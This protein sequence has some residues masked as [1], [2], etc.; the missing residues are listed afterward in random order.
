MIRAELR[1]K[2]IRKQTKR[3]VFRLLLAIGGGKWCLLPHAA[4]RGVIAVGID[5]AGEVEKQLGKFNNDNLLLEPIGEEDTL[6][7]LLSPDEV[8]KADSIAN[9][10]TFDGSGA[11]PLVS[12]LLAEQYIDSDRFRRFMQMLKTRIISQ[13]Q[14]NLRLIHLRIVGSIAGGYCAGSC[15][16]FIQAISANL[17]SLGVP[18]RVE[19]D[20]LGP[21]AYNKLAPQ[22]VENAAGVMPHF[23]AYFS[24]TPLEEACVSKL[25]VFSEAPPTGQDIAL[26]HRFLAL[27]EQAIASSDF[28]EQFNLIRPNLAS[29]GR[30]AT[31]PLKGNILRRRT[32]IIASFK[33]EDVI[34]SLAHTTGWKIER[35]IEQCKASVLATRDVKWEE[36]TEAD[37][38]TT[39]IDKVCEDAAYFEPEEVIKLL[40]VRRFVPMQQLSVILTDD[41]VVNPQAVAI[42]ARQSDHTVQSIVHHVAKLAG[43][44]FQ[45]K[46]LLEDLT[47]NQ[48][49]TKQAI[50]DASAAFLDAHS[51][52]QEQGGWFSFFKRGSP[53]EALRE[54]V[55]LIDENSRSLD[56]IEER[57]KLAT[58]LKSICEASHQLLID[59]L[60]SIERA[61]RNFKRGTSD[62]LA[63]AF[64]YRTEDSIVQSLWNFDSLT[65]GEQVLQLASL[66]D[67]ITLPGLSRMLGLETLDYDI[68][69]RR[70]V[71]G[72]VELAAPYFGGK[73]D[74]Q[75]A[76]KYYALPRLQDEDR[77]ALHAAIKNYDSTAHIVECDTHDAGVAVLRL[78]FHN[79]FTKKDIFRGAVG[80]ELS[81]AH[82]APNSHMVTIGGEEALRALDIKLGK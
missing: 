65:S 50:E 71:F 7:Q 3:D 77:D 5:A 73:I 6:H 18:I 75:P 31:V 15:V 41:T 80:N 59:R 39:D 19:G 44:I 47:A 29:F 23:V 62:E 13:S 11:M 49:E 24:S 48:V 28:E 4:H 61:L 42:E 58:A 37:P 74:H 53:E 26:R 72:D 68:M 33:T 36:A 12:Q 82:N 57:L 34:S 45:L 67:A 46:M 66:V 69:A 81:N 76:T 20:F 35:A 54:A 52:L 40:R 38:N 1:I 63:A 22:A 78:N 16:A 60:T 8:T 10:A 55:I 79:C 30:F 9:I 14:G 64:E 17:S 27:E 21:I 51:K 43:V 32:E 2:R 25:V 56:L 70:I